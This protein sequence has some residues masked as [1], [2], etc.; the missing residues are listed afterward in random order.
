MQLASR[1]W[2]LALKPLTEEPV[3]GRTLEMARPPGMALPPSHEPMVHA[4]RQT[5]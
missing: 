4:V 5:H 3:T 1:S 2:I